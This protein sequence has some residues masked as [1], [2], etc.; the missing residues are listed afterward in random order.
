MLSEEVAYANDYSPWHR[1]AQTQIRETE[2]MVW[3]TSILSNS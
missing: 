2:G 1:P 3:M